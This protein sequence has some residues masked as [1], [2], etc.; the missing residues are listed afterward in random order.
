VAGYDIV[1]SLMRCPQCAEN[2]RREATKCRYCQSEISQP[3]GSAFIGRWIRSHPA[4]AVSLAGFLYVA[5]QIHKAADFE[6]MTTVELLRAAGVTA[7]LTGVF[8]VQLPFE[9]LLLTF[10]AC[11]WLISAV[12]ATPRKMIGPRSVKHLGWIVK[13]PRTAP[14][15]ILAAL[16]ILGFYTSPWPLISWRQ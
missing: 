10:A 14:Q 3:S 9:L 4:L 7:I 2:I 12:P 6:V 16:L 1:D 11:W 15:V 13:D 5:F 8:R